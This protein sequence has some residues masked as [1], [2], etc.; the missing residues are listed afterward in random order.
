M[1]GRSARLLATWTHRTLT[2]GHR[3]RCG[4]SLSACA[5]KTRYIIA[6]KAGWRT[7]DLQT[8]S[9]LAPTGPLRGT[10]T[11]WRST[12]IIIASPRNLRLCCQTLLKIFRFPC[13]SQWISLNTMSSGRPSR[14]LWPLRACRRC[15]RLFV[16]G[17]NMSLIACPSIKNS[18]GLIRYP[19]N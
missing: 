4:R 10:R 9:Q 11:S 12:R 6:K 5:M 17:R 18:T 8:W 19:L 15:H 14:P 16:S 1:T 3:R 2:C 7:S 13:S